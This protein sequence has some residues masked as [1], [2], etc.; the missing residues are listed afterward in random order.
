[1]KKIPLQTTFLDALH[2]LLDLA[3]QKDRIAIREIRKILSRRG[4]EALLAIFSIPIPIPGLSNLFGIVLALLGF[5]FAI[6]KQPWWPKWILNKTVSSFHLESFALKTIQAIKV[7]RK[8]LR[9]R[10]SFF[11]QNPVFYYL[12]GIVICILA[13]IVALPIPIP[14]TNILFATPILFMAL[15][16][17]EDDGLFV[18]IGYLI[19]FFDIFLFT[20]L[21]LLLNGAVKGNI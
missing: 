10:L 19:I 1:M 8:V 3:K 4:T 2:Q 5:Q 12:N 17:L 15:G 7:L 20:T 16:L 11:I 6:G 21:F 13:C 9:P 14:F 18:L